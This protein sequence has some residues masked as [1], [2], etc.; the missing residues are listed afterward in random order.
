LDGALYGVLLC[1][2]VFWHEQLEEWDLR[3][4][5]VHGLGVW[6]VYYFNA[7]FWL[8]NSIWVRVFLFILGNWD[9]E[10]FCNSVDQCAVVKTSEN[11]FG[12]IVSEMNGPLGR[13]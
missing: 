9:W 2:Y 13:P 5:I 8:Y 12:K 3:G 1:G 7:L 10:V 4:W 11:F 6:L